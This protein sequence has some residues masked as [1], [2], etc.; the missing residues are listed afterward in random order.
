[1]LKLTA[2]SETELRSSM[3][4]VNTVVVF[5]TASAA[6][7]DTTIQG[8]PAIMPALFYVCLP[9]SV[10]LAVWATFYRSTECSS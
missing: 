3:S 5:A 2:L 7:R 6:N 9:L 1:M 10:G 8:H 4:K